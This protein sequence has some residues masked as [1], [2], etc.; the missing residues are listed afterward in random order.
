MAKK[1]KTGLPPVKPDPG[2]KWTWEGQ[3]GVDV[4]KRDP[5]RE[6]DEVMAG[7][8]KHFRLDLDHEPPD[9]LG[10]TEDADE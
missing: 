7:K 4:K 9:Y 6:F 8:R 5:G 2:G 1:R 10:R 3:R